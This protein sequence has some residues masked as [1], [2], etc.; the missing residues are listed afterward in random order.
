MD[1]AG[2]AHP[3]RNIAAL[4]IQ[5]GMSVADFG[6]GSGAYVLLMAEELGNTGHVYA[7]D[8][9]KDL[10]RRT[11]NE[12]HRRGFKHVKVLWG[13]LES[14]GGSKLADSSVDL[15]L[16][17]NLLFQ[18]ENKAAVMR[19]AAR[20]VRAG[21]HVAV[22]DWTDS[23]GGMGPASDAVFPATETKNIATGAGLSY[24]NDFIAGAHHYGLIFS[25]I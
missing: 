24:E 13:D 18:V 3:A 17:S 20:A 19:E 23:F 8:I 22:I 9:Q 15:V 4:G 7:I 1:T 10:L 11:Y 2:F 25:K 16:I 12:A 5:P 14:E 21:G 6:S